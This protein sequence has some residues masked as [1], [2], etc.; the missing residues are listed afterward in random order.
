MFQ[1]SITLLHRRRKDIKEKYKEKE[2]R[3]R[4]TGRHEGRD[5]K[6]E[7]GRR[8]QKEIMRF[9]KYHSFILR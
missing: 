4:E 8:K 3:G 6:E 7:E 9:T 1:E 2:K 5:E